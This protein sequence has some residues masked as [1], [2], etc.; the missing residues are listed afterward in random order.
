MLEGDVIEVRQVQEM[1]DFP[2]E[3]QKSVARTGLG[4]KR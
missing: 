2:P 3:I 4:K 1:T